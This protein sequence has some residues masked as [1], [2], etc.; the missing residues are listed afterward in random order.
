MLKCLLTKSSKI[1]FS[2]T[3]DTILIYCPQYAN[4]MKVYSNGSA[5]YMIVSQDLMLVLKKILFLTTET[6]KI[7]DGYCVNAS[8]NYLIYTPSFFRWCS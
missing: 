8:Q 4:R 6:I 3:A 2:K 7:T 1:L 5:T